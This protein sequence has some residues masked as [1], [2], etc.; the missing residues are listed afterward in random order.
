MLSGTTI[1]LKMVESESG[2]K[3]ESEIDTDHRSQHGLERTDE[4]TRRRQN[5]S[6]IDRMPSD[7][8][9]DSQEEEEE[10]AA[11]RHKCCIMM[12]NRVSYKE[13]W[14]LWLVCLLVAVLLECAPSPR[15]Q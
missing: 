8:D 10:K 6:Y 5:A 1:F 4:G 12:A 7:V 14:F 9:V 3:P 15:F 13:Q 2:S 11:V